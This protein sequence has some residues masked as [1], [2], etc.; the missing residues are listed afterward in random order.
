MTR[1][2][3]LPAFAVV[4]VVA[5]ACSSIESGTPTPVA[6]SRSATAARTSTPEPSAAPTG[7]ALRAQ[8]CAET[9]DALDLMRD[10]AEEFG[11]TYDSTEAAEEILELM[12]T[13]PEEIEGWVSE[14]NASLG[15]LGVETADAGIGADE[16]TWRDL[17]PDQQRQVERAVRD[18]GAGDC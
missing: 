11:E 6:D 7:L 4:A 3:L 16:P 14:L 10:F 2:L 9:K 15:E 13:D 1:T 18:A 8:V 17:T 12:R 5:S